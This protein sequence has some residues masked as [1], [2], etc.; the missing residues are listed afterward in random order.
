MMPEKESRIQP[1]HRKWTAL[2]AKTYINRFPQ[3]RGRVLPADHHR[4]TVQTV[5]YTEVVSGIRTVSM[6][7]YLG[8][9]CSWPFKNRKQSRSIILAANQ[10]LSVGSLQTGG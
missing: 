5:S 10:P 4:E 3:L 2:I 9:S 8:S 7:Y 6:N 1:T